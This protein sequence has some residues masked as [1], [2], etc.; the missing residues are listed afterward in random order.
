M[1]IA[2]R[3]RWWPAHAPGAP[4]YPIGRYWPSSF[5]G[6]FERLGST[7]LCSG[8][9]VLVSFWPLFMI[10]NTFVTNT[11]HVCQVWSLR[12]F[13]GICGFS[14]GLSAVVQYAHW[15][16]DI[17]L[18]MCSDLLVFGFSE[19]GLSSFQG[20]PRLRCIS[21]NAPFFHSHREGTMTDQHGLL[22]F[23]SRFQDQKQ[24]PR[25]SGSN[26]ET[27]S[28]SIRPSSI[29]PMT[30]NQWHQPWCRC[31]KWPW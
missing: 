11:R 9:G 2:D 26:L 24:F 18:A 21:R 31:H 8:W 20:V 22:C 15:P 16:H 23:D 12:K 7:E 1:S 19:T 30:V 25:C 10:P 5:A 6:V 3:E 27:S 29:H 14:D 13:T 4:S 28:W 17:F